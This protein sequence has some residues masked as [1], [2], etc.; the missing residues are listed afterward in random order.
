[1]KWHLGHILVTRPPDLALQADT[2]IDFVLVDFASTAIRRGHVI[3]RG[4][5]EL[6]TG[7]DGLLC[8][9]EDAFGTLLVWPGDT[10]WFRF[11]E[12]EV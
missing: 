12:F 11:D 2:D 1:M 9:I 10:I 3:G 5:A 6:F 8:V 4:I 7:G